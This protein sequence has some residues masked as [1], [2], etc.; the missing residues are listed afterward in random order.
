MEPTPQP[1][2]LPAN[3]ALTPKDL[4]QLPGFDPTDHT[5]P[6]LPPEFGGELPA[7]PQQPESEL[8]K[9]PEIILPSLS[10]MSKLET[11]KSEPELK[12]AEQIKPEPAVPSAAITPAPSKE[13]QPKK[14]GKG[15][16]GFIFNCRTLG[17]GFFLVLIGLI[18]LVSY[19]IIVRPPQLWIPVKEFL[20]AGL[21]VNPHNGTTLE[22]ATTELKLQIKEFQVGE[23]KLEITE[24]QLKPLVN[25]RL[26]ALNV[27]EIHTNI[28]QGQLKLYWNIDRGEPIPLWFVMQIAASKEQIPYIEWVGTQLVPAPQVLNT[29]VTRIALTAL[30]VTGISS[31]SDLMTVILPLPENVKVKRV[32]FE[33][34]KMNVILD[35]STGLDSIFDF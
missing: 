34:D 7:V 18:A 23:N 10:N 3:N 27:G 32:E 19:V 6:E 31:G 5:L 4:P 22:T 25:H 21:E 28:D 20:N 11:K 29:A 16:L 8:P 33:Q 9:Q 1:T 2:K 30:N 15:C 35:V 12:T 26:K 13:Q 14:Q 17:C 24:A